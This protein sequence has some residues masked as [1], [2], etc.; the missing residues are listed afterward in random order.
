MILKEKKQ[1]NWMLNLFCD[2]SIRFFAKDYE[3]ETLLRYIFVN[4]DGRLRSAW[5]VAPR[6]ES[7]RE[8]F[9]N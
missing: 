8:M 9:Q 2:L 3:I 6:K 1:T 4:P 5:F 7:F